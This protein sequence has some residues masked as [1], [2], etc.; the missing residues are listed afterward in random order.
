MTMP[1]SLEEIIE[2]ANELAQDLE[3]NNICVTNHM[4]VVS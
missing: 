2:H 3:V 1:R 4:V